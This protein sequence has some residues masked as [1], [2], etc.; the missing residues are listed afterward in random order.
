MRMRTM[1]RVKLVKTMKK[2]KKTVVVYTSRNGSTKRY[3]E[4]ISKECS[5]E[6]VP[7]DCADIDE[8]CQYET[9]VFGGCVYNGIIQGISFLKNNREILKC[10]RLFVFS[11]GLTQPGDEAAYAQVLERNF[12]SGET[13][14]IRFYHFLG[15][16]DFKKMSLMQ[17]MMMRVLKKS[18][19]KKPKAARSQM[20]EYILE[21]YGGKIDFVNFTYIKPL[22]R[23]VLAGESNVM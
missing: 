21:F 3:A 13:K 16:L 6:L 5:A 14:G 17:R 19:Q 23:D 12:E 9:V 15:T 1:C 20:E 10:C 22:V 8:V 11:V 4:W 18:I 2:G 7:L